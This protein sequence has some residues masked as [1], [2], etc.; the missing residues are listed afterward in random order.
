MHQDS[1]MHHQDTDMHNDTDVLYLTMFA[2]G[3]VF[4]THVRTRFGNT[5]SKKPTSTLKYWSG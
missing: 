3:R 4:L 5:A 1:D 2:S